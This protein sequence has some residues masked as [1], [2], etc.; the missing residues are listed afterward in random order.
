MFKLFRRKK[1]QVDG[2]IVCQIGAHIVAV[3]AALG[4]HKQQMDILFEYL[5]G[6]DS[7]VLPSEVIE[8]SFEIRRYA[9]LKQDYGILD[10][11]VLDAFLID[12]FRIVQHLSDA[13][14][15]LYNL[16]SLLHIRDIPIKETK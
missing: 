2:S 12:V 1:P 15:K 4:M 13:E 5:S 16:D 10:R 9:E 6:I 8:A 14:H 11:V 3:T 7:D